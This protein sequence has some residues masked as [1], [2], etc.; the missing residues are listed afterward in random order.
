M[1]KVPEE[2]GF[3]FQVKALKAEAGANGT[4]QCLLASQAHDTG[5]GAES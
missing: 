3:P 5:L 1:A 2:V 4:G